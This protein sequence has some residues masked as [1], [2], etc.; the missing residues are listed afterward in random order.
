[1]FV[2]NPEKVFTLRTPKTGICLSRLH[3][4][5]EQCASRRNNLWHMWRV[6]RSAL[7]LL[8]TGSVEHPVSCYGL[9]TL[10]SQ[11]AVGSNY[12]SLWLL[13]C[14]LS[15]R[16]WLKQDLRHTYPF[17]KTVVGRACKH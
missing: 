7:R 1:M 17:L 4:L 12:V 11:E 10:L 16:Q 15:Q 14:W 6:K 5:F 8:L 3:F 2:M 13:R 9:F